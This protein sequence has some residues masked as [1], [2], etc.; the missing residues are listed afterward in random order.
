ME[1]EEI[2]TTQHVK[3][4]VSWSFNEM[5]MN[6]GSKSVIF[7]VLVLLVLAAAVSVY[8]TLHAATI[9]EGVGEINGK[10]V[11]TA[12]GSARGITQGIESGAED[13][14][15]KGLSAEDTIAEVKGTMESI[16]KLEVFAAD[17]T[18]EYPIKIGNAYTGL[19]RSSGDAVF[20]VDLSNAEINCSEDGADIYIRIPSPDVEL[21]QDQSNTQKL[22]EMQ[23][24]SLSVSAEDGMNAYL[25]SFEKIKENSEESI[26]NYE[27]LLRIAKD[28]A[29]KQVEQLTAALC[30]KSQRIRVEFK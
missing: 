17:V 14:K 29:K 10:I 26:S 9:G 5:I 25:N 27:S 30:A 19:Y 2:S 12:I 21:Y 4:K 6:M 24:F 1:G 13:G 22:A 11:G 7:V 8:I 20:T 3:G 23:K 16:G 28:S 18:L 15:D